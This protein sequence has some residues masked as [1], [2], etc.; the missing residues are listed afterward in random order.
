M[1]NKKVIG[2][3]GGLGPYAG[4][5]LAR[6]IFDQTEAKSDPEYLS[7]ALLSVPQ[8]IVDRT[9]FLLGK[10][11]INPALAIFRIIRKLEKIG[12][13][14]I[15]IPCNT[16]HSPRIFNVI[17]EELKKANSSVKLVNMISEVVNFFRENY[18]SVRNIGVLS[19]IGVYKTKVYSNV[20]EKAGISVI[21]PD[22]ILQEEVHN[23]TYDPKYGIKA[24]S[25]PVTKFAKQ[26]ILEVINYLKNEGAEAIILGCTEIPLAVTDKKMGETIL[27]DPTFILARALIREVNPDKLKP[28][29]NCIFK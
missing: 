6:K 19:T 26:I 29:T 5:D 14:V 1:S 22:E 10:V 27:I 2:I 21:L 15:G 25:N 12:A 23:A 8:E 28:L 16:A 11:N 4:L 3:V 7:V 24:Q 20:L 18:P 9:S 17:L 13:G